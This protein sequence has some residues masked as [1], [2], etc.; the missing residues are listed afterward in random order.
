MVNA[1]E[2]VTHVLLLGVPAS[3]ISKFYQRGVSCSIINPGPLR[4][5]CIIITAAHDHRRAP[6]RALCYA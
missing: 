5:R 3:I 4:R 2:I 1:A 6:L